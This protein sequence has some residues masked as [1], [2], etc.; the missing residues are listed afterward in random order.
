MDN[1]FK[2]SQVNFHGC[3]FIPEITQVG[4]DQYVYTTIPG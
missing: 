1:N 2:P 4:D 3:G